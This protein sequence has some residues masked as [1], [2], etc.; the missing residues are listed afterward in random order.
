MTASTDSISVALPS[1]A[2]TSPEVRDAARALVAA[3]RKAS[4]SRSLSASAYQSTLETLGKV[5]G[6]PLALPLLSGGAGK[7]AFVQLADGRRVLDLVSG[8]G[9]YV[10]GHDDQDLLETGAIAAAADVAF[11]GH[12]LPG[13]EYARLCEALTRHAGERFAHAWLSLSGSMA[14]ENAWKM[15]L[16]HHAPASEIIT[17]EH[18]F[19][20]RTLAMSEL[21]D[22][23]EYREGLPEKTRVHRV[24]FFNADV[25]NSTQTSL[26]A[27]NQIL[28]E[29]EGR[30][31]AM[32][33]ELVQ[34]EGG[35]NAAPPAF[36]H[37]LMKRCKAAGIA[38]WV[39]EIQTF[40]R[41]GE[42][43]AFR[44][45]GLDRH[46]DLVTA[47]KVLH[48][49]ATLITQEYRPRPKLVAGTWAGATVGMAIGAR[50]I[51]R[52]ENEGH[53]GPEGGIA[54][55]AQRLDMAFE[56]LSER[57]PGVI[58]KRSGLGAMQ[59]FVVGD[60]D[61]QQT[62]EIIKACLEEGVLLQPAGH[63][64][65]K[66]RLLPPLSLTDE[67]IEFGFAAIERGITRVI[68]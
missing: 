21:T 19:H 54:R 4:R 39:D 8:I 67:E 35:F 42:L 34:G 36:F 10:F 40:A 31:A 29:H 48:G 27:L 3:V 56:R 22:R 59:A 17:F 30:V 37:A 57:L 46:V 61:P 5:R 38:V 28:I 9:P 47:G 60:G 66:I 25:P 45:L 58:T 24:P 13:L 55:L 63:H 68:Q 26:D 7:G 16:Q 62:A 2:Q 44:T 32:C 18:A 41:T 51:E 33:F 49:S 65:I 52:L 14:N 43:F 6:Q 15:I 1:L 12:V 11:Q 50:V 64:P 20:G 23:P 53:L